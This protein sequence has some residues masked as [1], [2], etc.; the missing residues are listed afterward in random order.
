VGAANTNMP[1]RGAG[2][3]ASLPLA[4]K[5][6]FDNQGRLTKQTDADGAEHRTVYELNK[7]LLFPYWVQTDQ[8]SL[9][10]IRVR[11]FNGGG[12]LTA[13]YQYQVDP[14]DPNQIAQ[15]YTWTKY[16]Y[17]GLMGQLQ[18]V[19]RYHTISAN[20]YYRTSY[21]YDRLGRRGAIIQYVEA[22]KYQVRVNLFDTLGRVTEIRSGVV[23]TPPANYSSLAG[24]NPATGYA[25]ISTSE[26][27]SGGVGDGHVTKTASYYDTAGTGKY[28]GQ[29]LY[30]TFRG[31]VRGIEPVDDSGT[32]EM[33]NLGPYTVQDVDWLGRVTATARYVSVPPWNTITAAEGDAAYADGTQTGRRT[34]SKTYFDDAGRV[35]RAAT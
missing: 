32:G 34:L 16:N 18:S 20:G 33:N 30:R 3:P 14:N 35:Y 13:T 2:L 21:L 7:I 5:R 4:T 24:A 28:T 10:P 11:E 15:K 17:D 6:Y 27:D 31:Y 23:G 26:Y 12:Q 29:R 8:K 1:T 25:K 22:G 9:L 19:D